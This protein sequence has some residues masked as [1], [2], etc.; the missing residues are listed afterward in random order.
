MA[1]TGPSLARHGESAKL[2]DFDPRAL[3]ATS[4]NFAPSIW[5]AAC[6][7]PKCQWIATA[8]V[9]RT[10][11][12]RLRRGQAGASSSA[13]TASRAYWRG[14]ATPAVEALRVITESAAALAKDSVSRHE[15]HCFADNRPGRTIA[16]PHPRQSADCQPRRAYQ[17]E[18]DERRRRAFPLLTVLEE[19][20]RQRISVSTGPVA[21]AR[22][23]GAD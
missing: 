4:A 9:A 22:R 8:S 23:R 18:A 3:L 19:A 12:Q 2:N 21:G 20:G 14:P 16:E 1:R 10:P 7:M 13:T 6:Q 11:E 5:K 17:Q 15:G